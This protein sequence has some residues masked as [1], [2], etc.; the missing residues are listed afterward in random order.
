MRFEVNNLVPEYDKLSE[1]SS[2]EA[3]DECQYFFQ[4]GRC[5]PS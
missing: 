3:A 5:Q 4:F 2:N 1:H